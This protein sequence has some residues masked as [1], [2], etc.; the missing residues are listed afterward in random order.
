M[1]VLV[2][3]PQPD[4]DATAARLAAMGHE[5]L[6]DPM[7]VV[8]PVPGARLPAGRFDAVVLT[9]VNGAR[10]LAGRPELVGLKG[11]PLYTVGR[12]TAAAAPEGFSRVAVAGGDGAALVVL[13]QAELPKGARLLHIAGEERAV[14]LGAA[15]AQVG[16]AVELFV[17]Y[18]AVAALRLSDATVAALGGG[19]IDVALHF[20]PR[21]AATLAARATEA[22]LAAAL[23]RIDHLCF[24]RNVAAPLE[25]AGAPARIAAAPTEEAL[26]DLIGR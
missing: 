13:L 1:R 20:S 21:T 4:A 10:A 16:I 2:T 8:E 25:A 24:S 14:D 12:R 7:L 6:V 26:L 15:L 9:S 19:G 5:A 11:L 18:R 23:A 17:I 3:R 22:G